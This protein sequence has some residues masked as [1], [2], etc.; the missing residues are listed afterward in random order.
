MSGIKDC[1][2]AYSAKYGVSIAEAEVAVKNV[3]SVI[4]DEIKTN[5]GVSFIGNFTIEKVH[6]AER[7]G[8]NPAT[9]EAHTIPASVG[10]KIKLGKQ[11]KSELNA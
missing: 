3:L 5:G 11:L 9:G 7:Q 6:R 8:R 4:T 10:L 1:A 2:K